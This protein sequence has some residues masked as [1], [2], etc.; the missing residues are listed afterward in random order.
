MQVKK[1]K[2]EMTQGSQL[3]EKLK[4]RVQGRRESNKDVGIGR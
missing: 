3:K 4:N 2:K 1:N